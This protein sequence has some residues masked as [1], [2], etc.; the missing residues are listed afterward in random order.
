MSK[1]T[2]PS[3]L[4]AGIFGSC[5]ALHSLVTR[6]R[7]FRGH[8]TSSI[9][10]HKDIREALP[11]GLKKVFYHKDLPLDILDELWRRFKEAVGGRSGPKAK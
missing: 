4:F 1:T 5:C 6:F 7:P 8:R 11:A 3:F 10:L 2:Q 9:V